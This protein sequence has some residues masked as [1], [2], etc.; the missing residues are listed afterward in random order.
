M[1]STHRLSVTDEVRF[2]AVLHVLSEMELK[3]KFLLLKM[4]CPERKLLPCHSKKVS[5]WLRALVHD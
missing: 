5:Q 3:L 4:L 2:G 1:Q